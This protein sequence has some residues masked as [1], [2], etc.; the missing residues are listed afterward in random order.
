MPDYCDSCDCN[1][2]NDSKC[3]ACSHDMGDTE[4]YYLNEHG[5]CIRRFWPMHALYVTLYHEYALIFTPKTYNNKKVWIF[6]I[7]NLM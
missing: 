3:F 1:S 4:A 7:L 2:F 5:Q 6:K